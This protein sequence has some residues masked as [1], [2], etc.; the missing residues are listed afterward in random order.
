MYVVVVVLQYMYYAQTTINSAY[1]PTYI[2]CLLVLVRNGPDQRCRESLYAFGP[3]QA[4]GSC[5]R[6][7]RVWSGYNALI[8]GEMILEN[9]KHTTCFQ[10]HR[11][12]NQIR[13]SFLKVTVAG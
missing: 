12:I 7:D 5:P 10:L 1:G 8:I 11:N 6:V 3:G 2:D 4:A 13:R 9:G